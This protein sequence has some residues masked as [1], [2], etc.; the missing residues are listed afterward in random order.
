MTIN[1]H[2]IIVFKLL[3]S[4]VDK[5]SVVQLPHKRT[6]IKGKGVAVKI[7]ALQAQKHSSIHLKDSGADILY[8]PESLLHV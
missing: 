7:T 2:H 4:A 3:F 8:R 1:H 6:V 5:S